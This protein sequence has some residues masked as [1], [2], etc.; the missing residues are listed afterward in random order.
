MC[1]DRTLT[2]QC[3]NI[4]S[5]SYMCFLCSQ[6]SVILQLLLLMFVRFSFRLSNGIQLKPHADLSNLCT[7]L[8]IYLLIR[9]KLSSISV[10]HSNQQSRKKN[11][12]IY[13]FTYA[14]THT[15]THRKI[16][17]EEFTSKWRE[18]ELH[19]K[20]QERKEQNKRNFV[21]TEEM[22]CIT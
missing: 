22:L 15:P 9:L 1:S 8:F 10:A 12:I 18:I 5:V 6:R 13:S 16:K 3:S 19:L 21:S 4:Y 7:G 14:H 11:Q 2:I 17:K 20:K